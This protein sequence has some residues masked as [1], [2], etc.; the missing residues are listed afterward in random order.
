MLYPRHFL[1]LLK[2][3]EKLHIKGVNKTD[4]FCILSIFPSI[5]QYALRSSKTLAHACCTVVLLSLKNPNKIYTT[6]KQVFKTLGCLSVLSIKFSL[7][8][9]AS[10]EITKTSCSLVVEL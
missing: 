1:K 3:I 5:K 2:M 8:H 7:K 10:I 9:C 4:N 6:L